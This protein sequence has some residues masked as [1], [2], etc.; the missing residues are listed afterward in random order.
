[1][2]IGSRRKGRIVRAVAGGYARTATVTPITGLVLTATKRGTAAHAVR[3]RI[4]VAGASTPLS[5]SVSGNDIT[6]N[7]ATNGSSVAT[8][9]LAQAVTAINNDANASKLVTAALA[10]GNP[11]TAVVT[12]VGYTAL[13][14]G[15]D[16]VVG[17]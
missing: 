1:M 17:G 3:F 15:T 7:S 12:A 10:S 8:T 14:G 4:V 16:W 9:T 5:V 6:L 2:P 13:A 11:G